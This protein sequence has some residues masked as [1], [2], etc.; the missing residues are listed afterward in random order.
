MSVS[1]YGLGYIRDGLQS[2]GRG[3]EKVADAINEHGKSLDKTEQTVYTIHIS[4]DVDPELLAEKL[5]LHQ[6][7]V[8]QKRM[9]R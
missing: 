7:H 4:G 5:V 8:A 1:D 9:E 6:A 2:I 3:L